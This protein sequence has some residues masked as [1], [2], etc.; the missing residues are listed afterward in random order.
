MG[1]RGFSLHPGGIDGEC[2][3]LRFYPITFK[4]LLS[5][6]PRIVLVMVLHRARNGIHGMAVFLNL[7]LIAAGSFLTSQAWAFGDLG[8][9]TVGAI[10]DAQLTSETRAAV[11]SLLP[12]GESLATVAA[13]PDEV[14]RAKNNLGPLAHDAEAQRFNEDFPDNREWH[15]V[16]LPLDTTASM[17]GAVGRRRNDIVQTIKRCIRVIESKTVPHHEMTRAQALRWLVHL[18]GDLHQPLHLGSGYYWFDAHGQAHLITDPQ[19]AAGKDEDRGGTLLF[20]TAEDHL[21]AF[22]DDRLVSA[23]AKGR[24]YREVAQDLLAQG[25]Q[26]VW[27][28]HGSYHYWVDQWAVESI[29]LGKSAYERLIFGAGQFDVDHNSLQKITITLPPGYEQ[30]EAQLV[31]QQLAKAGYRLAAILNAMQFPVA[32]SQ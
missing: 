2:V 15:Y 26:Q 8:H 14:K 25:H 32:A 29:R 7:L 16:D 30:D 5:L 19:E 18:L 11:G 4:I 31:E 22:W 3:C 27:D 17:E 6:A 24:A 20:Y 12:S 9:R 1:R 10:A 21:H 28:G 13:W 23:V